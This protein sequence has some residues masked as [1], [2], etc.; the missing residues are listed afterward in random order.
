M[1][2]QN[3]IHTDKDDQGRWRGITITF[4]KGKCIDYGDGPWGFLPSISQ[5]LADMLKLVV[6]SSKIIEESVRNLRL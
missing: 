3:G 5:G 4:T 1:M 6:N 2:H